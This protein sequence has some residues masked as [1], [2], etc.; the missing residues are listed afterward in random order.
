M[1]KILGILLIGLLATG[2][3]EIDELFEGKKEDNSSVSS[4]QL[5]AEIYAADWSNITNVNLL[6][7]GRTYNLRIDRNLLDGAIVSWDLLF[8]GANC[9]IQVFEDN[10]IKDQAQ[11]VCTTWGQLGLEITAL[12]ENGSEYVSVIDL[13]FVDM[14]PGGNGDQGPSRIY[15]ILSGTGGGNWG[16]N[17]WLQSAGDPARGIVYVG[18]TLKIINEDDAPHQPFVTNGLNCTN[19]PFALLTGQSYDCKITQELLTDQD[20]IYD[21]L[22]SADGTLSFKAIDADRIYNDQF[23]CTSCHGHKTGASAGQI[24]AAIRTGGIPAMNFLEAE[25]DLDDGVSATE[26]VEAMRWY[27]DNSI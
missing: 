20:Y 9:D 2:C 24:E 13:G 17:G 16:T 22:N 14:D 21:N 8:R 10:G 25:L 23:A 4:N 11:I 15:R 5:K 7:T 12:F 19:A 18:Q 26:K 3:A 1:K 6:E 27:L